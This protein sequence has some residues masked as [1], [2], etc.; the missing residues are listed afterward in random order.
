MEPLLLRP[1][2]V[3]QPYHFLLLLQ[4]KRH[5][6]TLGK[7][8]EGAVDVEHCEW[9]QSRDRVKRTVVGLGQESEI[10]VKHKLLSRLQHNRIT[11]RF[12][13]FLSWNLTKV[14]LTLKIPAK[15]HHPNTTSLHLQR[16]IAL[17]VSMELFSHWSTTFL[18]QVCRRRRW[19]SWSSVSTGVS[20]A[21][22]RQPRTGSATT[23]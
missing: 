22:R 6:A 16:P 18:P 3:P 14:N 9:R 21:T 15:R 7:P 1:D 11:C 13:N 4:H 2:G 10:S 20:M 5:L 8:L 17:L 12:Q 23:Q 19:G